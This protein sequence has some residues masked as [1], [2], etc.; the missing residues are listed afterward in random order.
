GFRWDTTTQNA[1]CDLDAVTV[2]FDDN[3][4][5]LAL[6]DCV[7]DTYSNVAALIDDSVYNMEGGMEEDLEKMMMDLTRVDNRVTTIVAGVRS[8]SMTFKARLPMA[9]GVSAIKCVC[10]SLLFSRFAHDRSSAD[11]APVWH[12]RVVSSSR[13]FSVSHDMRVDQQASE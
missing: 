2:F 1:V 3:A 7:Q 8:M 11:L 4:N 12:Q 10:A 6:V 9:H 5:P 13:L